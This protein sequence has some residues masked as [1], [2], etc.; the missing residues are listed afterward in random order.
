MFGMGNNARSSRTIEKKVMICLAALGLT[1][2]FSY[3]FLSSK[4]DSAAGGHADD[5]SPGGEPIASKIRGSTP[6]PRF[7]ESPDST[8]KPKFP[9]FRAEVETES[10]K[11][12]PEVRTSQFSP[13]V[14]ETEVLPG[15]TKNYQMHFSLGLG[16]NYM[17]FKHVG[18]ETRLLEYATFKPFSYSAQAGL[19]F[20]NGFGLAVTHSS[21]SGEI[22]SSAIAVRHPNFFW[23]N[24]S[25]EGLYSA[26]EPWRI[27]LGLQRHLLPYM[28]GFT[29][30]SVETRE[31]EIWH[32][33]MGTDYIWRR[34]RLEPQ[35]LLRYQTPIAQKAVDE[36]QL[37]A[38]AKF[39]L[40][41]SLGLDYW[42]DPQWKLGVFWSGQWHEYHYIMFSQATQAQDAGDS[43][44]FFSNLEVRLGF[45]F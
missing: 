35:V 39:V 1:A 24:Q 25:I 3:Y 32:A 38:R 5:Q 33:S 16:V 2:F 42:L 29:P 6:I 9:T 12:E 14:V 41:G 18:R 7:D 10:K 28:Q 20:N 31:L 19:D 37:R 45:K 8:I 4:T 40:E 21:Y 27:R 23:I 44:Y 13:P 22:Q 34:G 11:A 36:D 26:F 30:T 15:F 17:E 43:K